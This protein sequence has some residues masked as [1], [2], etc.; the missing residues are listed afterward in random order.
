MPAP[1]LGQAAAFPAGGGAAGTA[2]C[3]R[4]VAEREAAPAWDEAVGRAAGLSP[5]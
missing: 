1:L 3:A 2:G 4:L 5:P